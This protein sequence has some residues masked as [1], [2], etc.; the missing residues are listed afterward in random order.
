MKT[1]KIIIIA[2][3]LQSCHPYSYQLIELKSEVMEKNESLV[4]AKNSDIEVLFNFWKDGGS[5]NYTVFNKTEKTIYIKHDECQLIKNGLAIDYYD[6][7]EYTSGTSVLKGFTKGITTGSRV[8]KRKSKGVSNIYNANPYIN[9]Y[10]SDGGRKIGSIKTTKTSETTS[11][12]ISYSRTLTE[13]KTTSNSVTKTDKKVYVIPPNSA[14][15]IYG[16]R[17]QDFIFS[18]DNVDEVPTK[19]KSNLENG[20]SF[21]KEDSPLK[22]SVFI[23]YDFD[24]NFKTRKTFSADAYVSRFSNWSPSSFIKSN[25]AY[26]GEQNYKNRDVSEFYSSFRY[27]KKYNNTTKKRKLKLRE[28]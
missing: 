1:F 3:L 15:I 18:H 17:L 10:G 2:L 21:N 8:S 19:R 23:T 7:S 28:L 11:N 14:R 6:N 22:F 13:S 4:T 16:L 27:F 20:I 5:T 9:T 24:E 12:M 25:N 26:K